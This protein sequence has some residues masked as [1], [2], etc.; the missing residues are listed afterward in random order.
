MYI[1]VSVILAGNNVN[2]T[3]SLSY[4]LQLYTQQLIM[5]VYN[6]GKTVAITEK[7]A[8][9]IWSYALTS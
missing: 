6:N 3:L 7:A 9:I 1:A 8:L 5:V 2:R 4:I